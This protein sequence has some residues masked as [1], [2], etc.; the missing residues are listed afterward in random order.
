MIVG[1]GG[2]FGVDGAGVFDRDRPSREGHV[3]RRER[4][5]RPTM[6]AGIVEG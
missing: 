1:A 4:A 5:D 3:V 6:V 2:R